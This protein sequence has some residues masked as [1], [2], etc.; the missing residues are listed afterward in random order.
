MCCSPH[1]ASVFVFSLQSSRD[2][3]TQRGPGNLGLTTAVCWLAARGKSLTGRAPGIWRRPAR[4]E[5]EAMAEHRRPRATPSGA[6][7]PLAPFGLRAAR[8]RLFCYGSSMVPG[9]HLCRR[10]S[11]P[12]PRRLQHGLSDFCHGLLVDGRAAKLVS[13][14]CRKSMAA[15]VL[16]FQH[17]EEYNFGG[18]DCPKG[19]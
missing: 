10:A 13:P 15:D 7:K 3:H 8:T 12:D 1:Y 19:W 17:C 6:G 9:H 18:S 5:E 2:D 11:H 14:D 16:P 4:R